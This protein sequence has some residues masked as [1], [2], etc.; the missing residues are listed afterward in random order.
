MTVD[1]QE[2]AADGHPVL[3]DDFYLAQHLL[4]KKAKPLLPVNCTSFI[5]NENGNAIASKLL[6]DT[7]RLFG[8]ILRCTLF[9]FA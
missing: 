9:R 5:Y 2:A 4:D 6:L 8:I 1:V 7:L 3:Y